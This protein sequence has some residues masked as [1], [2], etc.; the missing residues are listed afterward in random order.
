IGY[1]VGLS[2][3]YYEVQ[4]IT[5]SNFAPLKMVEAKQTYDIGRFFVTMG[6]IGF[7]MLF[8]KSGIIAFLQRSLAAV[9]RMALSNYLMH[10]IITSIIFLG[11]GLYG[12]L[13]RYELYYVVFSI[14]IFQLIVSPI[15]LRYFQF[16]PFEWLWRSLTYG[17]KQAFRVPKQPKNDRPE[18]IT[19]KP[20]I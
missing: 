12:Q 13:E 20:A 8:I 17:K 11:F 10:S 9:G 19:V 16:G 6:H 5:E 14:W 7:F 3:N 18:V 15:W 4:L 1:A 2:V